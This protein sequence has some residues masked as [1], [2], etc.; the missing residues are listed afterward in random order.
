[1]GL[2]NFFHKIKTGFIRIG[3]S[4][5]PYTDEAKK[6]G[7]WGE[8]EFVYAIQSRLPDCKIKKNIIIETAEGNAE[9]DCLVLYKN[10]L[11][12]IEVKRWRGRLV[13]RDGDFVQY[14]CDRYTDEIH[15]KVHKSPFKQLGRAVYLLRKQI[16]VS[17]WVNAVVFFE[18]SDFLE[19]QSDNVWFDEIN[20]LVSYICNEGKV[21][22]GNANSFFDKCIAADYLYC[23]SWGNSLHCI[24][25]DDSLRFTTPTGILDRSNIR[26][27]YIRH[28]WSYDELEIT[29]KDGLLHTVSVE[30]GSVYVIDNGHLRRYALC[31]LDYIYLAN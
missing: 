24:V 17:A 23:S 28:H 8:D 15:T 25:G 22:W 16:P 26:S 29:T 7:D 12:A 2:L 27:I 5:L 4:A 14:K 19:S 13:E 11:F 18:E 6:Y 30:N 10:K 3:E 9:I 20:D 21:S 1:M 31:K